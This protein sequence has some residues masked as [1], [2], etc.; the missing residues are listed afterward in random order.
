MPQRKIFDGHVTWWR[1]DVQVLNEYDDSRCTSNVWWVEGGHDDYDARC[2]ACYF[3][4]GH[5][6]AYHNAALAG[7]AP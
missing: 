6:L 1:E 2:G 7:L 4:H 3:G 5:S